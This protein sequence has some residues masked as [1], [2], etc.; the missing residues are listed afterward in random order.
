ML[1]TIDGVPHCFECLEIVWDRWQ[2][3]GLNPSAVDWLEPMPYRYRPRN[4]VDP[5]PIDDDD[6]PGPP[7]SDDSELGSRGLNH[8]P[9]DA[10]VVRPAGQISLL[11]DES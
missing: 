3:I 11:A 6:R 5:L 1:C 10:A 4:F 7:P 8:S 2:A 9:D